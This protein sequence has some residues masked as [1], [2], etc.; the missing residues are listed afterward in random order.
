MAAPKDLV[1]HRAPTVFQAVG[2]WTRHSVSRRCDTV[3]SFAR[4]AVH[5]DRP[6]V[7]VG[8]VSR[9]RA[10]RDHGF[11]QDPGHYVENGRPSPCTLVPPHLT[12]RTVRSTL[13]QAQHSHRSNIYTPP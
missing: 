11:R 3:D 12:P 4:T 5:V 13:R 9:V 1:G 6:K 10:D 2:S 8:G 7:T